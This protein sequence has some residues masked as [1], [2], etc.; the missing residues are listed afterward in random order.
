MSLKGHFVTEHALTSEI[1]TSTYEFLY[2]HYLRMHRTVFCNMTNDTIVQHA[3]FA[4]FPEASRQHLHVQHL[5][6]YQ[7]Q[8]V[9]LL[10]LQGQQLQWK[11]SLKYPSPLSVPLAFNNLRCLK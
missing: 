1:S 8:A 11:P 4:I 5:S 2:S 7:Y 9:R 6:N 10:P 3:P